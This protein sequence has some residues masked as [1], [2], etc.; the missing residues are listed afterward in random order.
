MFGISVVPLNFRRQRE[1]M[2]FGRR[3]LVCGTEA[4]LAALAHIGAHPE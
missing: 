2:P 3:Q 1:S 4:A